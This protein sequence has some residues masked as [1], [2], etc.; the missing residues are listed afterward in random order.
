M[1][2]PRN[3]SRR[4][5]AL[6]EQADLAGRRR[7]VRAM[8][9]D[10]CAEHGVPPS[11]VDAITAEAVDAYGR[12]LEKMRGMRAAGASEREIVERFAAEMDTTPDA[13]AADA[14]RLA[15]RYG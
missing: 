8:V 13:L 1:E 6:E 11:E 9:E 14:E 4:L 2:T 5:A 10:L 7:R 3:L 15:A 12:W